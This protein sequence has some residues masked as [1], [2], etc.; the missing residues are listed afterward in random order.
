MQGG[1][2]ALPHAPL[3]VSVYFIQKELDMRTKK[4]NRRVLTGLLILMLLFLGLEAGGFQRSIGDM[5]QDYRLDA[6]L[7]GALVSGQYVVMIAAPLIAGRIA[8]RRSHRTALLAGVLLFSCGCLCIQLPAGQAALPAVLLIGTGYSFIECTATAL[9]AE[10]PFGAAAV[11]GSQCAFCIGAVLAP[12]LAEQLSL[13]WRFSFLIPGLAALLLL[14]LL[15]GSFRSEDGLRRQEP[16]G[17]PVFSAEILLLLCAMFLYGMLENGSAYSLV[18]FFSDHLHVAYGA[19]ALSAFWLAMALGRGLCAFPQLQRIPVWLCCLMSFLLL[20]VLALAQNGI[21]AFAAAFLFGLF[22]APLW[23][24]MILTAARASA[25]VGTVVGCMSLASCVGGTV[26][27][28][29]L[30]VCEKHFGAAVSFRVLS[31]AAL[32]MLSITFLAARPAIFHKRR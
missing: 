15:F 12:V 31:L 19:Y 10:L 7:A 2:Q 6:A 20:A 24:G 22:C 23:P 1:R 8:D 5:A 30:G 11:N 27:P 26:S 25:H 16:A 9:L 14:P 3:P 17:T 32:L 13:S 18:R 21:L 4:Q 29:L 28:L